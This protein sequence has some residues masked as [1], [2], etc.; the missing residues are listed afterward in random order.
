MGRQSLRMTAGVINSAYQTMVDGI[1]RL[2][3]RHGPYD[4]QWLRSAY[5]NCGE[6]S[7]RR[8]VREILLAGEKANERPS[9]FRHVIADGA[10][11]HRIL[12]LQGIEDRIH[13]NW[14][15]NIQRDF[16]A[17]SR[18]CPQML[19]QN[20]TYHDCLLSRGYCLSLPKRLL[21][22]VVQQGR[23]ERSE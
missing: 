18:E 3:S 1:L 5:H 20:H 23:K 22:M 4:Q 19:W 10:S 2:S 21:K 15:G 17:D 9:A 8:F 6:G 7:I 14:A 13:R 16:A 11:Q 12:T